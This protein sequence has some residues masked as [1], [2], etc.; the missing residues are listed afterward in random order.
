MARAAGVLLLGLFPPTFMVSLHIW[1]DA[2]MVSCSLL[3]V[4]LLTWHSRKPRLWLLIA[5][6]VTGFWRV[7]PLAGALLLPYLCWVG[8]AL[9]LNYAVWQLNPETLGLVCAD[10]GP[11]SPVRVGFVEKLIDS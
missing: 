8:F 2:S 5:A 4:A 10:Q 3:A 6:T 9:A 7:R 11:G 1:K